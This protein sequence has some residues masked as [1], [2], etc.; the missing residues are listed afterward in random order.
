[1][2]SSTSPEDVSTIMLK[3]FEKPAVLNTGTRASYARQYYNMYAGKTA[4]TS[5]NASVKHVNTPAN[6]IT[7]SAK[8][9]RGPTIESTNTFNGVTKDYNTASTAS[10][11]INNSNGITKAINMI[12]SLLEAI[13]GNTASTSSKL[14]MLER[15]KSS[16]ITNVGGNT[17]NYVTNTN[18]GDRV[19]SSSQ[20]SNKTPSGPSRNRKIAELIAQGGM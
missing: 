8:G 20:S 9:G 14:D 7:M 3:E 5:G 16:N 12:I 1:M 19:T 10:N 2:A 11:Y 13:T 17:T 6:T 18:N 15:L 4:P